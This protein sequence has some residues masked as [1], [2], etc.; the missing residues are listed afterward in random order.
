V[1]ADLNTLRTLPPR[2]L[3]AGLAEVIKHGA[4]A[5]ADFLGWIEANTDA[6]LACDTNSMDHAVLRSCEF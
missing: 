4:I 3:S 5:D 1:I 6:L 2:E